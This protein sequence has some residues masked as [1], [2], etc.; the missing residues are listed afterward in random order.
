MRRAAVLIVGILMAYR[1]TLG[2]DLTDESYYAAFIDG[3]IKTGIHAGTALGLHQ[4]AALLVY[5]FAWLYAELLGSVDGLVLFLRVLYLG[6]TACVAI[7]FYLFV[8][9][10]A[11]KTV[12]AC[13]ALLVM[14]FIPFSLPAPSY[15]TLGML[16][17]VAAL[18][19]SGLYLLQESDTSGH[20]SL[21]WAG[22]SAAAWAV[23]VVAYPT[24]IAVQAVFVLGL[25][26]TL[27]RDG[28]GTLWRYLAICALTH[29]VGASA[30]IL[31][32]GPGKL[33]A[34]LAFSNASL[35]VSSGFA[36]KLQKL[37]TPFAK[38]PMF[39]VLGAAMLGLGL[40]AGRLSRSAGRAQAGL[41]GLAVSAALVFASLTAPA[42]YARTHDIVLLLALLG[43]GAAMASEKSSPAARLLR[44]LLVVGG[45]GGVITALTATNGL[46][47]FAVGGFFA[48]ALAL[49][50]A[51]RGDARG[52]AL[53]PLGV[54]TIA[55]AL[56]LWNAF[57]F[58]YGEPSNPLLNEPRR[59]SEGVFKN[60]V[61]HAKQAQAIEKTTQLLRSIEPGP[62]SVTVFGR[63]PGIY[64]L[65][66][67]APLTLSTWDFNQH[68]APLPGIER[69]RSEFFS[70]PKH[71]AALALVV[72]D[73]WTRPPSPAE[74]SLLSRYLKCKTYP[75][76]VF[77]VSIHAR[78][79][80]E[81]AHGCGDDSQ[82]KDEP[83]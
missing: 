48:A 25:F 33:Q 81:Q 17:L 70:D 11:T 42:L 72:S 12:A 45:I 36:D 8:S 7:V 37:L 43:V 54:M 2:V 61:T 58:V 19:C 76:G 4:T 75:L 55:I 15:N 78:V 52:G 56:F 57:S 73:P 39:A 30:L 21:G 47:N 28:R 1:M 66:H 9:R 24:L 68:A 51:F 34:M 60:L 74:E 65:T 32:F 27:G 62:E 67:A 38:H 64:L 10:W 77:A 6:V 31:V 80:S 26:W 49:P 79:D 82:Q 44:L 63:L 69:F 83:K 46:V 71:R 5:P 22:G 41:M 29:L 40:T 59:M 23:A 14:S 35:Q 13:A 50:M 53:T 16:G 20:R 3:W 18:S